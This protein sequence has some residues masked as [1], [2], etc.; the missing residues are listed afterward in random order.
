M[1]ADEIDYFHFHGHSEFAGEFH[2][3]LSRIP[4]TERLTRTTWSKTISYLCVDALKARW[5]IYELNEPFARQ[6][7]EILQSFRFQL[8]K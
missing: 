5:Y 1:T 3:Y 7:A 6:L 4:S 2:L 8:R